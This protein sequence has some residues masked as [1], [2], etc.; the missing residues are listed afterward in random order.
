[1]VTEI[2]FFQPPRRNT[3][4]EKIV[5]RVFA[6]IASDGFTFN[7]DILQQQHHIDKHFYL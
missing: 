2:N 7:A 6:S 5:T 4:G 3:A 1:M